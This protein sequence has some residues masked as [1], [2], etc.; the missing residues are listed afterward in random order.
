MQ[1]CFLLGTCFIPTRPWC[2][3]DFTCLGSV[4]VYQKL[5]VNILLI[6]VLFSYRKRKKTV[7]FANS[8][9]W[10]GEWVAGKAILRTADRN[11][12]RIKK[13]HLIENLGSCTA[14][15]FCRKN[16]WW[17]GRWMFNYLNNQYTEK[18]KK[19]LK[20]QK[21]IVTPCGIKGAFNFDLIFCHNL[22]LCH[23]LYSW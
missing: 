2:S 21:G 16:S 19:N 9:R 6:W 11:Q 15:E 18:K 23:Q 4:F 7:K 20:R 5:T 13:L 8:K 10:A 12:M 3:T 22:Y 17:V 1:P 14:K